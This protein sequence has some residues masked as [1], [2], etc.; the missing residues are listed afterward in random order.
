MTVVVVPCVRPVDVSPRPG[1]TISLEDPWGNFN[2]RRSLSLDP[3]D[4]PRVDQRG[5]SL[6]R[7]EALELVERVN[8]KNYFTTQHRPDAGSERSLL[9]C[10][11]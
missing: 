4:S 9:S 11:H 6:D 1:S 7:V 3:I 8:P 5:H 10:K 2:E